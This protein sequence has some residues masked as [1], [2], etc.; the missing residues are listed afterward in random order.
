MKKK[1]KKAVA[2]I[3]TMAMTMSVGVPAFA[4][5]TTSSEFVKPTRIVK[6]I[7]MSDIPEGITPIYIE[8]LDEINMIMD[9]FQENIQ[10]ASVAVNDVL[11]ISPMSVNSSYTNVSIKKLNG[12]PMIGTDFYCMVRVDFANGKFT[13]CHSITSGLEGITAYVSWNETD[14][15]E[16]YSADDTVFT[17]HV[18]GELT[19]FVFYDKGPLSV[20]DVYSDIAT[21]F[22][23]ADVLANV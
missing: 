12:G 10:S 2:V 17:A 16:E 14:S 1:F 6:Q 19:S 15:W 21:D 4:E 22:T 13:N 7:E 3:L 11:G 18:A 5:S 8:S 20:T 9:E 23:E